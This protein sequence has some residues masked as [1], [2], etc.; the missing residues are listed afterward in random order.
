MARERHKAARKKRRPGRDQN[1]PFLPRAARL[2]RGFGEA[3]RLGKRPSA[4]VASGWQGGTLLPS[5]ANGRC[6][7]RRFRE[8]PPWLKEGDALMIVGEVQSAPLAEAEEL[9]PRSE[10]RVGTLRARCGGPLQ[11]IWKLRLG[12][13]KK[14]DPGSS[15]KRAGRTGGPLEAAC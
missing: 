10:K 4:A 13:K 3:P 14:R 6:S 11:A 15:R 7:V 5:P 1:L 9:E 8:L 12:P 2:G